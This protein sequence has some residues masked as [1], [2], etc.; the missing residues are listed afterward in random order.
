MVRTKN[1]PSKMAAPEKPR[2]TPRRHHRYRPGTLALREI[3]RYQKSTENLIPRQNFQRLVREIQMEMN[4]NE[5]A[6]RWQSV[7]LSALQV[8]K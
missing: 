1:V 2:P 5:E 3:R 6:I 8:S 7:A 4:A